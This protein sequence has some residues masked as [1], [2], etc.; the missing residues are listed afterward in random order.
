MKR[1]AI[2]TAAI[3]LSLLY[4]SP[5][6]AIEDPDPKG[7][8][9]VGLIA[10]PRTGACLELYVDI[11][12]YLSVDIGR[13]GGFMLGIEP[14]L[15]TDYVL[16]DS[17]WKGHFTVGAMLGGYRIG[18]MGKGEKRHHSAIVLAPRAMYGLNLSRKVEVHAGFIT[19]LAIT[20]CSEN[21]EED[22]GAA[23]VFGTVTGTRFNLTDNFGITADLNLSAY[24]PLL[25]VGV[26]YK[27]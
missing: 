16:V 26:S 10:G 22:E 17:W 7:T 5:A 20:F 25:S 6:F 19:G 1:F 23:F 4:A 11:D 14:M 21:V 13:K 27:F 24:T 8:V 12:D 9:S 18:T 2:F 3:I 15:T